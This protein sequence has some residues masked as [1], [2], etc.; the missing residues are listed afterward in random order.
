LSFFAKIKASL[1]RSRQV[2]GKQLGQLF[3]GRKEIDDELWEM[4]ESVLIKADLGI[5]L[6]ERILAELTDRVQRKE[7]KDPKALHE[8]LCELLAKRLEAVSTP[9]SIPTS[10]SKP[11]VILVVGVN[12]VGKTTTIGK[13]AHQFTSQKRSVLIAAG[14]TFRA[15]ATEQL[16]AWADRVGVPCVSQGEGADSASV[17]Y[18]AIQSA[19]AKRIDL[20]IADTAGRLQNKDHLMQELAKIIRVMKKC[21]PELPSEVLLVLDGGSGQNALIQAKI[22]TAMV[23]VTGLVLTKLDGTA[24]GGALFSIADQLKLPIRYVGVGEQLEDLQPFDPKAFSE[25]LL[26]SDTSG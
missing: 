20:V 19:I 23:G 25:A 6:T 1:T 11:Y 8:A 17:I 24:K 13:L 5:D 22:F 16:Q 26:T 18:D 7:C 10:L 15:A 3:L 21:D 2:L 14:D 9:W 4:L 12:G